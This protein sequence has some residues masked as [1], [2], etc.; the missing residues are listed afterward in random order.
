MAWLRTMLPA[1]PQ[2]QSWSIKCIS[3]N[4]RRGLRFAAGP[5]KSSQ[6][7]VVMS[8]AAYPLPRL[9]T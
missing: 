8:Q 1:A 3:L 7:F 6:S 2:S 5:G 9:R 4:L